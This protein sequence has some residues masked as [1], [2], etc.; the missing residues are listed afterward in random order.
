MTAP[1]GLHM[2]VLAL[3]FI[4]VHRLSQRIDLRGPVS[5]LALTAAASIA[6]SLLELGFCLVFD[7]SFNA[8]ARTT[9]VVLTAMLPQAL[10]TA[11]FGPVIFWL[12]GQLEAITTRKSESIYT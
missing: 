11:P 7:Q 5:V 12:L 6:T 10:L 9:G 4:V 1:V 3:T 2:E 8:S